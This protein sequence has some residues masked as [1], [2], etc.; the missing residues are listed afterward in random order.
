MFTYFED[1]TYK[2][3]K[4]H[5]KKCKKLPTIIKS[6]DTYAINATTSTSITLSLTGI[7]WIMIPISASIACGLTVSNEG[8]YEVVVQKH[9]N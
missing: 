6:L 9:N 2:S 3:K 5:H 4:E 7:A 8:I 1:K